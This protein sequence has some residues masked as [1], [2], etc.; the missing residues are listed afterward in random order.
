MRL[1]AGHHETSVEASATQLN[2]ISI[3]VERWMGTPLLRRSH[4]S[5]FGMNI[6]LIMSMIGPLSYIFDFEGSPLTTDLTAT[7]QTAP[8]DPQSVPPTPLAPLTRGPPPRAGAIDI[9]AR[10]EAEPEAKTPSMQTPTRSDNMQSESKGQMTTLQPAPS[11][12]RKTTE[13]K[14]TE[15]IVNTVADAAALGGSASTVLETT[16]I[17]PLIDRGT[18]FFEAGDVVAARLLFNRAAKAGDPTAA[19]ALGTTYDP[20]VLKSHGI[21]GVAADLE[22]ALSWYEIAGKLG[23]PEGLSPTRDAQ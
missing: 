20:T 13:S 6:L 23:S 18:R 21:L 14:T 3:K 11:L 9:A 19:L 22:K 16:N 4:Y 15:N 8:I 7:S 2:A 12:E 17:K 1:A 5:F 10:I